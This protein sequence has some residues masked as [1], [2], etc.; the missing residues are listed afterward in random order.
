[1]CAAGP[2]T[3]PIGESPYSSAA[4]AAKAAVLNHCAADGLDTLTDR[5]RGSARVPQPL[6]SVAPG[7]LMLSGA[8]ETKLLMPLNCQPPRIASATGCMSFRKRASRPNG[9]L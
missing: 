2:S 5:R 9:S 4:G 8:P 1:M 7:T 3:T 6:P